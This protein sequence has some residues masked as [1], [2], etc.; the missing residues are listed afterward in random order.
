MSSATTG[1]PHSSLAVHALDRDA[2]LWRNT[3]DLRG[4]LVA[5]RALLLQVAHPMVG[6]GV[7]EHSVY[8]TDPWGR[9]Y[10]SLASLM[11]QV[12]GRERAVAEGERLHALHRTIKG[13]DDQG[14]RYSALNPEA[15]YWVHATVLETA[16]VFQERFDEPLTPAEQQRAFEEWRRVGLMLGLRERDLPDDLDEFWRRWHEI[17]ARLENNAVVQDVLHNGPTKPRFLPVRQAWLD[18][19]NRPLVRLQRDIVTWTLDEDLH[20]LFGL[21][22]L[23]ASQERRLRRLGRLSRLLGRVLPDALR[24]P[25]PIYVARRRAM[26]RPPVTPTRPHAA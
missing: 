9:L 3:G 25:L 12:Y 5:V 7:G 15:F 16:F 22:P 18:A 20:E 8:K 19:L 2:V 21:A 11:T 4:G 26:A 10:R 17:R 24:F 13:V 6:A 23:T 1:C 14:R